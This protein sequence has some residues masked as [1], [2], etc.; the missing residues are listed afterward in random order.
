M[1]SAA[2]RVSSVDQII[3]QGAEDSAP[4]GKIAKRCQGALA[5][6]RKKVGASAAIGAPLAGLAA[7]AVS[8]GG[9]EAGFTNC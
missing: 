3:Y 8:L 5:S 9:G 6:H 1:A 4:S 7:T 2:A